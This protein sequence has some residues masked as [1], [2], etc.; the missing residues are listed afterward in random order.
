MIGSALAGLST[1]TGALGINPARTRSRSANN[2]IRSAM[3]ATAD[4][5]IRS[6]LRSI[7]VETPSGP[8]E[9][10]DPRNRLVRWAGLGGPEGQV[11]VGM[12]RDSAN[13]ARAA[14][15]R[16][17]ADGFLTPPPAYEYTS[18]NDRTGLVTMASGF[19]G[20][21]L[22][23]LLVVSGVAFLAIRRFIK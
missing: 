3:I 22:I 13:E 9:T 23:P 16:L 17:V 14:L 20:S 15:T 11:G 4:Q 10:G 5:A 1:V 2:A 19:T 12:P 7:T 21:G 6:G 18:R 8:P